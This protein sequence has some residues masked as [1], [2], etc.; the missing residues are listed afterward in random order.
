[1]GGPHEN[2]FKSSGGSDSDARA[3]R[4]IVMRRG[5]AP[6]IAASRRLFGAGKGGTDHHCIRTR[7]EGFTDVSPGGHSTVC[8]NRNVRS[9]LFK[10]MFTSGG[11]IDGGCHLGNADSKNT[12]RGASGTRSD[13]DEN[14]CSARVHK[15]EAGVVVNGVP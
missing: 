9:G 13:T 1:M 7:G 2:F 6:M 8:N 15:F 12:A 5:H 11:A 4:K 10:V 3:T 14:G